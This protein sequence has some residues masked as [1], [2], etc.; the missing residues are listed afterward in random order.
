MT[1]VLQPAYHPFYA[2]SDTRVMVARS[3]RRSVRDPE[4]FTTALALPVILMLLFVYVFG[5][6]FD[7]GVRQSGGY[8]NYVV[9]G[10]IVLCAGFGAGTTAVAVATD[11][12]S[13]IVDRFRSMPIAAWTV[14]AGQIVASLARNLLATALVIAVALAVGWRPAGGPA[15]WAGAIAMIVLFILAMS[16]LA[17]CFGLAVGSPEAA[18]GATFILMFVPY[19]STAFVPAGTMASGLRAIAA[20]QPFTP[21]IETMRGLWM[22][23]TS[24]GAS[25]GHEALLAVVYCAAILVISAAAASWLFRHRTTTR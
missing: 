4:A 8:V 23:R 2:L 7:A 22:G 18:T 16:W 11:M 24:T 12:S 15:Q 6:A 13:G 9:P 17:A 25:V 10:L 14:L 21:V 1:A 20:N 19:L 5:G 3:L